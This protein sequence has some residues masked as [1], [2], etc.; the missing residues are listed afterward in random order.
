M[1][2]KFVIARLKAVEP[3]L[4]DK[5]VVALYLY[6]SYARD[7][8]RA[9]SDIDIIVEFAS[10]QLGDL[11]RYMAP[12]HLLE[13]QLPDVPIGYGTTENIVPEYRSTIENEAIRIF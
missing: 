11:S 5:G 6:G 7:E 3:A 13:Q 12:Y 9:D 4:R 2:K 8:A 1:D 10:G